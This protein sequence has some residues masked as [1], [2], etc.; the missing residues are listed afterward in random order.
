M[1]ENYLRAA[2]FQFFFSQPRSVRISEQKQICS[3]FLTPVS[4]EGYSLLTTLRQSNHEL[5][6]SDKTKL[7]NSEK[8]ASMPKNNRIVTQRNERCKGCLYCQISCPA[9]AI[10]VS[11][12]VNAKG[13]NTMVIDRELCTACGACYTVCPDYVY[14]IREV[15]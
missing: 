2:F 5:I 11:A 12:Q 10:S 1:G 9:G 14:E 6:N 4:A 15:G 3:S 7:T 8:E 13:Y